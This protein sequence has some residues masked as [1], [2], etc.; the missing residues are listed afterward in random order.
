MSSGWLILEANL[1][2]LVVGRFMPTV[3]GIA[4]AKVACTK[5]VP[6]ARGTG[7]RW[8]SVLL[9]VTE[10]SVSRSRVPVLSSY[11]SSYG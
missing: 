10:R 5:K 8:D 1:L 2:L 9:S 11:S 6:R 4:I 7:S 3:D